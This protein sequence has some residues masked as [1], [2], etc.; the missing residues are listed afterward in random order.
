[1]L[2]FYVVYISILAVLGCALAGITWLV[3]IFHERARKYAASG[4]I[5]KTT[6]LLTGNRL[7]VLS[8]IQ[9]FLLYAIP[10]MGFGVVIFVMTG[11]V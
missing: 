10:I 4:N 1:M 2:S 6:M 5:D 11:N 3:T 9:G 8:S 7:R